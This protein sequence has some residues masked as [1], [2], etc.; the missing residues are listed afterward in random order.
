MLSLSCLH[1]LFPAGRSRG[2][3][4]SVSLRGSEIRHVFQQ[5][6]IVLHNKARPRQVW[7]VITPPAAW[8]AL[9]RLPVG[10]ATKARFVNFSWGVMV[11]CPN[12]LAIAVSTSLLGKE[13]APLLGLYE[14]YSCLSCR[15]ALAANSSQKSRLPLILKIAFCRLYNSAY[16][17]GTRSTFYPG[18]VGSGGQ[19]GWKCAR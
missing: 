17:R 14:F 8:S 16:D 18:P 3:K 5:P 13:V 15:E 11:A 19:G 10:L 2:K 6:L 1:M 9:G 7:D 4:S 12:Q